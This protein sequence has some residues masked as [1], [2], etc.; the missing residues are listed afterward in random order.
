MFSRFWRGRGPKG[1]L[2]VVLV[3]VA[4]VGIC[5]YSALHRAA[6][7]G[8][9]AAKSN[10]FTYSIPKGWI[11]HAPC[12]VTPVHAAGVTNEGCARPPGEATAGAYLLSQP[13]A[14]GTTAADVA[15]AL[16]GQVTGYQPCAAGAG[17]V[18]CLRASGHSDQ[19]GELRVRVDKTLAIAMLCLRTDRSDVQ[20]GCDV[21]WNHIRITS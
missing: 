5:G 17:A 14:Q 21:V 7:G 16:A 12:D 11:Y 15:D 10:R 19:K 9:V 13:V 3:V 4:V 8:S 2:V 6:T 18:A 1:R 20:R